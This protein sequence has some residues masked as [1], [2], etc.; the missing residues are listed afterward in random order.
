MEIRA[1]VH[2]QNFSMNHTLYYVLGL[3]KPQRAAL[4]CSAVELSFLR[5]PRR[6]CTLQVI[7]ILFVLS[8]TENVER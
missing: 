6:Q 5:A 2:V 3:R 4:K 1:C 7:F 8:V